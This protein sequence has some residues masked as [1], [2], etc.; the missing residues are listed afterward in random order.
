MTNRVFQGLVAAG[1]MALL[2]G[3]MAMAETAWSDVCLDM[4]RVDAPAAD[5]AEQC[6]SITM[7]P[8]SYLLSDPDKAIALFH[9]ARANLELGQGKDVEKLKLAASQIARSL[10]ELPNGSAYFSD[11]RN[12]DPGSKACRKRDRKC[13]AK[14]EAWKVAADRFRFDRAVLNA[15]ALKELG[16]AL[17][18]NP[19][20]GLDAVCDSK[21]S[22]L[23]AAL[24]SMIKQ[25][26]VTRPFEAGVRQKDAPEGPEVAQFKLLRAELLETRGGIAD[27]PEALG[28]YQTIMDSD[29]ASAESAAARIKVETLALSLAEAAIPEKSRPATVQNLREGLRYYQQ[30]LD[31]NP[32]SFSAARGKATALQALATQTNM[33]DSDRRNYFQLAE[34]A[35]EAALTLATGAERADVSFALATTRTSLA[36]HI[37]S[38]S[39]RTLQDDRRR[40]GLLQDAVRHYEDAARIKPSGDYLLALA[41]SRVAMG[42]PADAYRDYR[43]A[44]GSFLNQTDPRAWQVPTNDDERDEFRATVRRA[45]FPSEQRASIARAL[46][47]LELTENNLL[48]AEIADDQGLV[49]SM[50]LAE[51]YLEKQRKAEAAQRLDKVIL[52]SRNSDGV[53]LAGYEADRAR[54]FYLRSRLLQPS[55]D[56][57]PTA[58][59][60]S[61][62]DAAYLLEPGNQEYKNWACLIRILRGREYVEGDRFGAGCAGLAGNERELLRGMF[63]LRAAQFASGQRQRD[64]RNEAR[65]VFRGGDDRLKT[66]TNY[67]T[68][69][70]E[71]ELMNGKTDIP[72][73]SLLLYGVARAGSCSGVSET[74]DITQKDLNEAADFF[75]HFA[76]ASCSR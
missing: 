51:F 65:A 29:A 5:T 30:A 62:A 52:K 2:A 40:Q 43:A 64:L 72:L 67:D 20:A 27:R 33:A 15:R 3:P 66:E 8:D 16:T 37:G 31:A 39:P 59:N 23:E 41:D 69:S 25:S 58:R 24:E 57:E 1:L 56:I 73:R 11:V 75:A 44:I 61:D 7:R 9:A 19:A 13:N 22:C 6:L 68:L 49:S 54:A 34:A 55:R 26:S 74:P 36:D 17:H 28:V 12:A 47:N 4:P 32:V 18:N 71:F 10:S 35:W 38:L 50:K 53:I 70:A 14:V 60:V 21:P 46:L 76:V 63:L 45:D 48:A 42:Q